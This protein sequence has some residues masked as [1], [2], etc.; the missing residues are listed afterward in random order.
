MVYKA[1]IFDLDGTLVHTKPEYRYK[2]IGQTLKELGTSSS[3]HH[4]DRFWFET[5]RDEIIKNHFKL[6]PELFWEIYRKNEIPEL[7]EKF[8]ELYKDI[9]F[10]RE[11]KQKGFKIGIVTGAPSHIAH[12]EINMLGKENFDEIIITNRENRVEYKPHPQGLLECLNKLKVKKEEAIYVGNSDEDVLTAK[13]AEVFDVL[14]N[15]GEHIFPEIN[16]TLTIQSLY[17][18]RKLL[19]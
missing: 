12:V 17:E 4:I 18:L 5:R 13:N 19:T 8:T 2:I 1:V 16:P 15:R 3:D 14:L 10:I 9:D 7:R 6:D 11:L